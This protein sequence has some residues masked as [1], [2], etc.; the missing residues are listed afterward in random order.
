MA[1]IA[2]STLLIGFFTEDEFTENLVRSKPFDLPDG[3]AL[4]GGKDIEPEFARSDFG[5]GDLK[6]IAQ[7]G[8][9]HDSFPN[10]AI[11]ILQFIV[12]DTARVGF[13]D[14][15]AVNA[16][17]SAKIGGDPRLRNGVVR[18]PAGGGIAIEGELRAVM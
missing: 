6:V 9:G 3:R 18:G 1:M 14:A 11:P 5:K 13:A 10:C 4:F 8:T 15:N 17:G 12:L 16:P 7:G 2:Q